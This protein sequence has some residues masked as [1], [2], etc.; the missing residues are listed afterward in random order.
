MVLDNSNLQIITDRFA[1][2][3]HGENVFPEDRTVLNRTLDL[4]YSSSF[5][6]KLRSEFRSKGKRLK[7]KELNAL[8][9]DLEA[10]ALF[11][12]SLVNP[13][14]RLQSINNQV[15]LDVC[16]SHSTRIV[17]ADGEYVL[18]TEGDETDFIRY[19]S[20]EA[21]TPPSDNPNLDALGEFIELPIMQLLLLIAWITFVMTHAKGPETSYPIL[22]LRAGQGSGKTTLCKFLMLIID[23][24][25][26][27]VQKLTGKLD[28][29]STMIKTTHMIVFDNV[30]GF[31]RD[32]ADSL[33][34]TST[35]GSHRKRMLYSDSDE[36]TLNL[37]SV[38]VLNGI[39]AFI[40]QP[41][42][43]ERCLSIQLNA[44]PKEKRKTDAEIMARFN[45]VLPDLM[46]GF[47]SLAAK[48]LVHE[49]D[50]EVKYPMRM[51]GFA[52][53][54]AAIELALKEVPTELFN[55]IHVG[56]LQHAYSEN[57]RQASLDNLYQNELA[58]AVMEL[59]K[60]HHSWSGTPTELFNKLNADYGE[61]VTR[62]R[63]WPKTAISLGKRLR[64]LEASLAEHGVII[65][66][67]HSEQRSISIKMEHSK[68]VSVGTIY[69][70]TAEY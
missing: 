61:Q 20:A 40:E 58:A 26:Y 44:I 27:G 45:E 29:L 64:P 21:L 54:L 14:V 55:D 37:Q 17:L 6:A 31:T 63:H 16:D 66:F 70:E 59:A 67:G 32:M 28:D 62:A 53:W 5:K 3:V 57:L 10:E 49:Q 50:V 1:L 52:T 13:K 41:D 7:P 30:R 48:A 34:Q 15:I 60:K 51:M 47:L 8:L 65:D 23:P 18:V 25:S 36:V 12:N 35:G 43:Q 19:A 69:N 38:V 39:Y 56:A 2:H 4:L 11:I 9:E 42:L 46:A 24:R 22:V 33:C 68:N